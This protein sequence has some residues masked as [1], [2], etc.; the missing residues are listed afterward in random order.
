MTMPVHHSNAARSARLVRMGYRVRGVGAV[1]VWSDAVDRPR[2]GASRTVGGVRR[3]AMMP[4]SMTLL[5][6]HIAGTARN[7][8]TATVQGRS[9]RAPHTTMSSATGRRRVSGMGMALADARL[10]RLGDEQLDPFPPHPGCEHERHRRDGRRRAQRDGQ[11]PP[12]PADREPDQA[13][14]RRDLGQQHERPRPG[15][16][17]P[18]RDGHRQQQVDVA[19]DELEDGR[20]EEPQQD[21]RIALGRSR[22]RSR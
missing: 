1:P 5:Y 18:E 8:A 3:M 4:S 9:V 19:V 21:Q 17:E 14:T 16:A 7:A 12:L 11:R 15:V 10:A 20:R 2:T 13:D 22:H 6:H